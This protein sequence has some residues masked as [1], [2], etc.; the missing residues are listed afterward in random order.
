MKH[1]GLLTLAFATLATTAGADVVVS[2]CIIREPTPGTNMTAAYLDVKFIND[3]ATQALRLPGPEDL[4]NAFIRDLSDR[5]ELHEVKEVDGQMKMGQI[6]K[7][8]LENDTTHHLMP[9]NHHF[10]LT[11]LKKRPK[12][13][14]NYEVTLWFTYSPS[15]TC[16]AEVKTSAEIQEIF[17]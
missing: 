1:P 5:V 7:L 14:E 12:A 3:E 2:N 17:K 13:G 4:T 6:A 9:G 10:M 16:L 15:V 11:D 8:R